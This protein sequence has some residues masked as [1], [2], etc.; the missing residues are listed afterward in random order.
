MANND[1]SVL[2]DARGKACP[3]P[4][5]MT[6]K[7]VESAPGQVVT[8]IVDN[9]VAKEN[10][11]K[12]AATVNYDVSMESKE[13]LYYLTLTPKATKDNPNVGEMCQGIEGQSY[14]IVISSDMF[15]QGDEALGKLLMKNYIYAIKELDNKP[16]SMLFLNRG[17][18]L[19]TEGSELINDLKE[20]E[21]MGVEVISCGTCLDFY[22]LK[23]KLQVGSVGNMFTIAD[24]MSKNR[25]VIL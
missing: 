21:N 1:N 20:L 22:H 7:A 14:V 8:V 15:G 2:V 10:V 23:E 5:I 19:T 16:A 25:T 11:S 4:V 3:T 24:K 12:F 6:K 17:V 9:D 13:G 18:M